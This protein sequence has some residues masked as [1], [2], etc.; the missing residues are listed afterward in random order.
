LLISGFVRDWFIFKDKLEQD[1]CNF[2]LNINRSE[3]LLVG[4][5]DILESLD[6]FHVIIDNVKILP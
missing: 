5:K 4:S 2:L 3:M 6:E 1:I